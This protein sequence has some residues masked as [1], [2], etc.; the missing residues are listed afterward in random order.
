MEIKCIK[1][2]YDLKL[3]KSINVGDI[4]EVEDARAEELTTTNNKAG[5]VLA[6]VVEEVVE[7]PVKKRRKAA[8]KDV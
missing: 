1:A 7:A 6:E 4:L 5:Q 8:K 2:Y 3:K